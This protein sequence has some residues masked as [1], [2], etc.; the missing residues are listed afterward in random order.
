ML[1]QQILINFWRGIVT[2]S[3]FSQLFLHQLKF[4]LPADSNVL[5]KQVGEPN[6]LF[7]LV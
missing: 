3:S 2:S 4:F 7:I 1:M 6:E 5:T